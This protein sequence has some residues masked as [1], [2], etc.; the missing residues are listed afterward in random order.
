MAN[1]KNTNKAIENTLENEVK[2]AKAAKIGGITRVR[3]PEEVKPEEVKPEEVKPEEV[4]NLKS[5]IADLAAKSA[6]VDII[7]K[8]KDQRNAVTNTAK[9]CES[10][11]KL[12][13]YG[14]SVNWCFT[15]TTTLL[16]AVNTPKSTIDKIKN[17]AESLVYL[18]VDYVTAKHACER[19]KT[20]ER[21]KLVKAKK[22]LCFEQLKALKKI[23][24]IDTPCNKADIDILSGMCI[25]I[26][27][28][29]KTN[30]KGGYKLTKCGT[31]SAL[32]KVLKSVTAIPDKELSTSQIFGKISK[33]KSEDLQL[34]IA[35]T[36][37]NAGILKIEKK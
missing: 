30:I 6:K 20:P 10:F 2:T 36:A 16:T 21:E 5:I 28:A 22:S 3:K 1:K 35:D 37:I 17:T 27:Y 29:D 14:N 24:G 18:F 26:T 11:T 9:E 23:F 25:S 13:E 32:N 33:S 19:G 7:S 15:L 34:N 4:T 31:F 12:C 8:V